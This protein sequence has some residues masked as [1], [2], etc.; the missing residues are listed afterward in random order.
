MSLEWEIP[1]VQKPE[2]I[3]RKPGRPP[4]APKVTRL[5]PPESE[6]NRTRDAII[7]IEVRMPNHEPYSE[8]FRIRDVLGNYMRA[9]LVPKAFMK[10]LKDKI[11]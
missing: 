4:K 8:E 1:E 5:E 2:P 10:M 6:I 11:L 7:R 9:Q 3:K